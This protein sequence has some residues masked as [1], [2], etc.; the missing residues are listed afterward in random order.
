MCVCVCVCVAITLHNC[1]PSPPTHRE[2]GDGKQQQQQRQQSPQSTAKEQCSEPGKTE[3]SSES[4]KTEQSS[5]L[6]KTEQ[7]SELRKTDSSEEQT[8]TN[9]HCAMNSTDELAHE[10]AAPNLV[11]TAAVTDELEC[12]EELHHANH[13]ASS[14]TD[15]MKCLV[16]SSSVTAGSEEQGHAVQDAGTGGEG[17]DRQPQCR[18]D[19]KELSASLSVGENGAQLL[20]DPAATAAVDTATADV[21]VKKPRGRRPKFKP[22]DS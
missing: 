4:G 11:H 3:Q 21:L 12:T 10:K 15:E 17:E 19:K 18:E 2:K 20:P 1:T 6:G 7:S 8:D 5:E 13:Q 16:G 22:A 14:R 9:P